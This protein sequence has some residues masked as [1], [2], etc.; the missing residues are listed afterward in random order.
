MEKRKRPLECK[1]DL[2][3]AIAIATKFREATTLNARVRNS[4]Q[5]EL[6]APRCQCG[7]KM[8]YVVKVDSGGISH[9]GANLKPT[10]PAM[11]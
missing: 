6:A 8:G 5:T 2:Q 1:I 4:L 3:R 7:E 10:T 11:L 9:M